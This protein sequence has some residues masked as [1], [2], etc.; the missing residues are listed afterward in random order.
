MAQ[1]QGDPDPGTTSRLI[2]L[3]RH[4]K[5][6]PKNVGLSDLERSLVPEGIAE[7]ARVARCLT[8]KRMSFD[9]LLSSPADRALE[10]AHIFAEYL[11]YP[12]LKIQIVPALYEDSSPTGLIAAV[13]KID[14]RIERVAL[15][16]HNPHFAGLATHLIP[17][18]DREIA[19]GGAMGISTK[20]KSWSQL[21]KACG[22]FEFYVDP[23]HAS[24]KVG[25]RR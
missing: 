3:V 11:G 19:K 13:K 16:G 8:S 25:A 7:S 6:A 1:V 22:H 23:E 2:C 10:T 9:L 21:R 18:L 20:I 14:D 12:I 5:A 24:A 17:E 4:G 15:F